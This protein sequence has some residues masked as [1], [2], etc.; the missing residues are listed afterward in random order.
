MK[1]IAAIDLSDLTPLDL[2]R[3][4]D[5]KAAAALNDLSEASFRRH[6]RHIIRKIT[7]RRD[8]VELGDALALP[9]AP[10]GEQD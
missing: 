10:T 8:A 7:P 1:P 5:V 3:K 4:I 6:Y 2:R 9:P